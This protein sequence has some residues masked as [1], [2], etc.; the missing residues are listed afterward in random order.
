[1]TNKNKF[2]SLWVALAVALVAVSPVF[3]VDAK[4][5]T[6]TQAAAVSRI[7]INTADATQLNKLPRVG[8]KMAQRIIDFR[9][10]NGAFKKIEDLMKVKG[11]G[12]KVFAK[13]QP[14]IT[15]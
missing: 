12:P 11:I 10:A 9:K 1:M 14:Q 4:A 2:L 15:V 13:L 7:N 3:A 6:K 5:N 8:D